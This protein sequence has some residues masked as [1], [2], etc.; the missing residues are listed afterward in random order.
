VGVSAGASAPE[1]LVEGVIERLGDLGFTD[2]ETEAVAREDLVFSPPP[3]P[4]R[5]QPGEA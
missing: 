4:A 3:I 5:Q 2:V 1:V